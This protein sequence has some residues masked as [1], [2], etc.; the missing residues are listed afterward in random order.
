MGFCF[1]IIQG[2]TAKATKDSLRVLLWEI[3][4]HPPY[5]RDLSHCDY[6]EFCWLKLAS[7]GQHFTCNQA[8]CD[9]W[10]SGSITSL[11]PTSRNVWKGLHRVGIFV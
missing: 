4:N 3:L 5:S 2:R 7:K 1:R 10:K 8:V 6:H 11:P 9:A